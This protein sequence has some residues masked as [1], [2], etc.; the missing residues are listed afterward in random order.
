MTDFPNAHESETKELG[1][2]SPLVKTKEFTLLPEGHYP[3]RVVKFEKGYYENDT[4]SC[5]VAKLRLEIDNDQGNVVINHNIFLT[6][7]NI[8]MVSD[9]F[10]SI[11]MTPEDDAPP[12]WNDIEG[13]EGGCH[14]IKKPLKF[15]PINAVDR[16]IPR[17]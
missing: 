2:D 7:S 4:F 6:E 9:F 15:K 17:S 8:Q 16:F 3:F 10:S 12:A 5:P 1:W 11:G 13:K 14:L